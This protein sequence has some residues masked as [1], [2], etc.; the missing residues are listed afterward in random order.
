M[1]TSSLASYLRSHR[2]KSGLTQRELADII[3]LIAR[4][5]ISTHERST[6]IPSLLVALSYQVVFRIP[7]ADL[8]PGLCGSIQDNVEQRLAEFERTLQDSTAKG[9]RAQL[10]ARKLEW[11]CER[12]LLG[13]SS[14]Q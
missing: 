4:H 11:L 12:K 13:T 2:L 1:T 10:V 5:Q 3:G 8:F 6:A 7:V 14:D 9:R